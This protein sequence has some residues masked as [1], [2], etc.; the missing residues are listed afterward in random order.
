MALSRSPARLC[1]SP[2]ATA[3]PQHGK[4]RTKQVEEQRQSYAR[5]CG[6]CREDRPP[7]CLPPLA[8][9]TREEEN[10][11]N[12]TSPNTPFCLE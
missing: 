10:L 5:A 4:H 1:S 8:P 3:K 12:L 6:V 7:A 2:N 11:S 9:E